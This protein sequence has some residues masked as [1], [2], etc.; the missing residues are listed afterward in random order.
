MSIDESVAGRGIRAD[1]GSHAGGRQRG[2]VALAGRHVAG[3]LHHDALDLQRREFRARLLH[4]RGHSRELRRGGGS[5]AERS[6]AIVIRRFIPIRE[7]ATRLEHV[8][9]VPRLDRQH[10]IIRA[11]LQAHEARQIGH[12]AVCVDDAGEA[13]RV[14][15]GPEGFIQI[16]VNTAGGNHIRVLAGE[17]HMAVARGEDDDNSRRHGRRDGRRERQ[18]RRA[19]HGGSAG[20]AAPAT[21]DDVRAQ[22]HRR[23]ECAQRVGEVD[24]HRQ[25]LD[26]RRAGENVR[27]FAGAVPA[28]VLQRIGGTRPEQ[29]GRSPVAAVDEERMLEPPAVHHGDLD[30]LAGNARPVHLVGVAAERHARWHVEVPV[31]FV[32]RKHGR[33]H[34]IPRHLDRH[35]LDQIAHRAARRCDEA[36]HFRLRA[37]DECPHGMHPARLDDRPFLGNERGVESPLEG[38]LRACDVDRD[39]RH[40]EDFKA[41]IPQSVHGPLDD[42]LLRDEIGCGSC[43]DAIPSVKQR[44]AAHR[45]RRGVGVDDL[46]DDGLGFLFDQDVWS[47]CF[48]GAHRI[49]FVCLFVCLFALIAPE[50]R[51]CGR[52][53]VRA[54]IRKPRNGVKPPQRS[55]PGRWPCEIMG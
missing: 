50:A 12:P 44:H 34:R 46:R 26:V 37:F 20:V 14:V 55:R 24:L 3:G 30:V 29:H 17:A 10:E 40:L 27:G 43:V 28:L 42:F 35:A 21:G 7:D 13:T 54:E 5:T 1:D 31:G 51:K 47:L 45:K 32:R 4:E 22:P 19:E 6:P 53:V 39:R 18:V 41:R 52:A 23:V 25:Q 11:R 38:G 36:G 15:G 9:V 16:H 33:R 8:D 49:W 2:A 48:F